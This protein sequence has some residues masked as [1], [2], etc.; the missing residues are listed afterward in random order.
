MKPTALTLIATLALLPMTTHAADSFPD[1][2]QLPSQ[3]QPPDPLVLQNGE[4]VTTSTQWFQQRR[5]ELKALFQHYMHGNIPP[6][7]PLLHFDVQ[8]VDTNFFGGKATKKE[9]AISFTTDT[10]APVINLLLVIPNNRSPKQKDRGFPVFVGLNFCGNHTLVTD[11]TVAL[12]TTWMPKNCPGCVHN[13]ATDAGRGAQV[14]VWNLEQSIDRGYAVATIY[15]GD[16]EPDTTNAPAGLRA[17]LAR[18]PGV[19]GQPFSDCTTLGAWAWGL[20]RAVDYIVTDSALDPKRIAVT[21]HSRL[22]KAAILAAAF[23]DRFA[24]AVPL[25]SGCGGTSPSRGTIGESV[26]AINTSFPH[27]FNAEFKKFND[28]P[29]RL[30][31]DQNSLI[32]LVAP[33]PVLIGT[34]TED[35][36]GNPAGAFEMLKATDP[37]YRLLG[38]PGLDEK[39]MPAE[40]HLVGN[41][42]AYFIRP[43]KHS[44]TKSDW[45]VF[46]DY[47]DK[48][49]P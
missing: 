48:T 19:A 2:S 6:A 38:V 5:P 27:W 15:N 7:P 32:A 35:T 40:N 29:D 36:W 31:F 49:M 46:L 4:R 25:Q 10:N 14:E 30:P 41:H 17:W 20:S 34:A 28:Q 43:G 33:R 39:E 42:L 22:G 21:G 37:V 26:K 24:L 3:P 1:A 18:Q 16:I 11:T 12:P 45:Q 44:M 23:D 47:A 9:V 8:R 13:H